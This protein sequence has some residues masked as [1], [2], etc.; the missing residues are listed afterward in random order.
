M[1][2]I[3]KWSKDQIEKRSEED[4]NKFWNFEDYDIKITNIF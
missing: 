4:F 2:D 3:R 1:I